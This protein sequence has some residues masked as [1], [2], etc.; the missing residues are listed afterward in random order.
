MKINGNKSLELTKVQ[1]M[2]KTLKIALTQS[3]KVKKWRKFHQVECLYYSLNSTLKSWTLPYNCKGQYWS[4]FKLVIAIGRI[5]QTQSTDQPIAIIVLP[6][7]AFDEVYH[8]G[9]NY[10]IVHSIMM[11]GLISGRAILFAGG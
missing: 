11:K 9:H 8:Q 10:Y 3:L 2:K 7:Y 4:V 6:Q 5:N 1:M